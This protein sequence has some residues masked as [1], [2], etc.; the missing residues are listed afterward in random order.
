[1]TIE[2]AKIWFVWGQ[3]YAN[4]ATI[5]FDI[6]KNSSLIKNIQGMML[7]VPVITNIAFACELM[8]KAI[9]FKND[10]SLSADSIKNHKLEEILNKFIPQNI[11]QQIRTETNLLTNQ[12][13]S[14]MGKKY[15]PDEADIAIT[16]FSDSFYQWRY[17]LDPS[18]KMAPNQ[19]E[20]L[21]CFF[22]A[23]KKNF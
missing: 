21:F 4:A 7:I 14:K 19:T 15:T 23:C 20:V 8:L 16:D 2:E 11:R 22:E 9:A 5:L 6:V 3:N 10:S 1:M 12:K 13:L 18:I 17:A